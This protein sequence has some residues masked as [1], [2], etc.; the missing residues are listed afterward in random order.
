MT[1]FSRSV[2]FVT[3][4]LGH[5]IVKSGTPSHKRANYQIRPNSKAI[6][7]YNP[8]THIIQTSDISVK[9]NFFVNTKA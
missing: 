4:F 2:F 9:R 1:S 7:F 6:D 5:K 3:T 8:N